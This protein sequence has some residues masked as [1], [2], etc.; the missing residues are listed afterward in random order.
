MTDGSKYILVIMQANI[1]LT[2]LSEASDNEEEHPNL[3]PRTSLLALEKETGKLVWEKPFTALQGTYN[4]LADGTLYA[5]TA[6]VGLDE[7]TRI[8]AFSVENGELRWEVALEDEFREMITFSGGVTIVHAGAA[9]GFASNGKS[10]YK[11][12]LFAQSELSSDGINLCVASSADLA[13]YTLNKG[14]EL[15]RKKL[16][17][18]ISSPGMACGRVLLGSLKT[19]Q[20]SQGQKASMKKAL[21]SVTKNAEGIEVEDFVGNIDN[22]LDAGRIEETAHAFRSSDGALLWTKK[23]IDGIAIPSNS[24]LILQRVNSSFSLLDQTTSQKTFFDVLDPN[25]GNI[26][27]S[28]EHPAR[29]R[30]AYI[31]GD[32]LYISGCD[33]SGDL[34]PSFSLNAPKT[35]GNHVAV[36]SL[37][38]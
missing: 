34:V 3:A 36:I 15:W 14:E 29:V 20:Y 18:D 8:S 28:Y 23:Q 1:D 30:E 37:K 27:W 16:D 5:L 10:I 12:P 7:K 2:V 31:L 38:W 13:C 9:C 6:D 11:I 17:E 22:A 33:G 21:R 26:L 25:S 32:R 4:A 19:T 24:Y 35:H